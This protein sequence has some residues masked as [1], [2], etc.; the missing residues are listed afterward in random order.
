M[1]YV[2]EE[3][4]L[5]QV[6]FEGR[7][8]NQQVMSVFT[9]KRT[10]QT[11]DIPDGAAAI[12]AMWTMLVGPT[13]LYT[14]WTNCLSEKVTDIRARLQWI[15]L[16]RF[17]YIQKISD[18][19]TQGF[20]PGNCMP[21]NTSVAITKRTQNAGRD[22]VGTIHMP[23]VPT[24]FVND[25]RVSAQGLILYDDLGTAMRVVHVL[26]NPSITLTP[27]LFDKSTPEDSQPIAN[28]TVQPFV[29]VMRRRTVGLGS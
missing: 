15:R 8:E 26:S 20:V 12:N 28:H 16:S 23:G 29:R 17:A 5:L 10:D 24:I 3:G 18:V 14:K 21:V 27:V 9:F 19:T 6:T 11:G 1:A 2:I 7:H 22:Q 4:A 13:G 25:G